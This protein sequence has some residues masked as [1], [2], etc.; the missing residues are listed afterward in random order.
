MERASVAAWETDG[1]IA[2][3]RRLVDSSPGE[4]DNPFASALSIS[5][6]L[7]EKKKVA[8]AFVVASFLDYY[9]MLIYTRSHA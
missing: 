9:S 4:R 6:R 3:L 2:R 1:S 5:F 8:V 7:E